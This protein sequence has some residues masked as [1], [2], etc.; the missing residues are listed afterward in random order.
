VS[1][2]R[3]CEIT[4]DVVREAEDEYRQADTRDAALLLGRARTFADEV[5]VYIE[6]LKDRG[7]QIAKLL[8][9]RGQS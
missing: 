2:A 8:P 1:I 7:A 5:L 3:L 6:R 4:V 9:P